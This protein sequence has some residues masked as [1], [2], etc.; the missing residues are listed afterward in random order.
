M[1]W[2]DAWSNSGP[3][4]NWPTYDSTRQSASKAAGILRWF[5][6][7]GSHVNQYNWAGGNH[8]AR[9]AGS[10]MVNAY[11]F[12]A[13]LASDNLA[14]G[15][16]R[17]HIAGVF[18]ALA[19]VA[20]QLLAS[21]AQNKLQVQLP[22]YASGA[23]RP[24]DAEHVAYVY[25]GAPQDV[26]FLENRGSGGAA[27]AW[28]GR[29]FSVA[30]GSSVLALA[31][32][33]V[34]FDASAVAP[35]PLQRAWTPAPP[36]ALANLRAW[37][38]PVVPGSPAAIPPP[39][40]RRA[41][42][43]GSALGAI[44]AA[45]APLEAVAFS[46]YDSE[47][48]LYATAVAPGALGAAIA[49]SASAANVTLA[50]AS[51]RAQAWAV[52]LNGALVGTGSELSHGG[53]AARLALALNLSAYAAGGGGGGGGAAALT[54]LSSSLGIDNGGGVSAGGGSS[55]VKGITS[56]APG[57]VTLGG[58]D[59]TAAAPWTHI[60]GSAGEALRLAAAPD[61]VPW[62]PLPAAA[63]PLAPLTWLRADFTAPARV[64]PPPAGVEAAAALNLDATGLS[65]GRFF[66]NGFDLGRYWSKLCGGAYMCQRYYSIPLDL[67]RA[68]EGANTLL[69]L[70]ELGAPNASAL[71]LAVSENLPPPP[72]PACGAPPPAGGP[73]GTFPCGSTF[74]AFAASA[75]A[76]GAHTRLAL[77][78]A[79]GLCLAVAPGA[80]RSVVLAACNASSA[81]QAWALPSGGS[82]PGQVTS[83][84]L[85][86]GLALDVLGQNASV[87]AALDMWGA[88]GGSNQAWAWEGGELRS[89]LTGGRL[90]AG[91]CVYS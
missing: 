37:R 71:A 35:A 36:G 50:L 13:P 58:I 4:A 11:Y 74:T 12:D 24:P 64:L 34:L 26:A 5:A 29:N 25:P 41:P 62:A 28:R 45:P 55:G 53:G 65:R 30:P 69:V 76:D 18:A 75:A 48:V 9:N 42:W 23:L 56:A 2:F 52:F 40:P 81:L 20:A 70:D 31:N 88:N 49:A 61:A 3:A 39:T 90:C 17:A 38:D 21:P 15:P 10:S 89:A 22:Y 67:L 47:L 6:R 82:A 72:P 7:G 54:L 1:G 84:A 86:A 44:V 14:Q 27:L 33:S 80:P 8:F 85:G 91:L 16:E 57:A 59:L 63:P 60:C 66:V 73:A 79:P 83:A 43:A 68:G 87:G 77:A 32:G 78:R 51:A 19:S 46:E